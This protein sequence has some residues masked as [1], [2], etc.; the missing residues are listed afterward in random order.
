MWWE[1]FVGGEAAFEFVS[2]CEV[3][4]IAAEE[5]VGANGEAAGGGQRGVGGYEGEEGEVGCAAADV[6][7]EEGGVGISA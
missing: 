6:N 4:V 3:E 7:Y 1:R 2:E 5:E